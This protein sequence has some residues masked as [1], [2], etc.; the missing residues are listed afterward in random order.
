MSKFLSG[1]FAGVGDTFRL[2]YH[3]NPRAFLIGAVASLTEPLFY[4]AL[5]LLLQQLFERLT[6][7]VGTN[8]IFAPIGIGLVIL[9]LVQRL[10]II[11]RDQANTILRQEAWVV[12]SRQIMQKLPSVP[13]PMFE[14][15][16]FQARYGLVIREASYR[17]ITLVD[18]LLSTAPILLGLL[19]VVVTLAAKAPLMTAAILVIAIPAAMTERRFS[20]AMYALQEDSAPLHLRMDALTNMQVDATWQRDVRVYRSDLLGREHGSLARS[21]LAQLKHLT[22][23]FFRL[24]SA[25]ALVQVAGLGLALIAAFALLRRGQLSVA[26]LAVL[27]P[28]VSI[29]AGMTSSFVYQLRDLFESLA[30]ARALFEFLATPFSDEVHAESPDD[31]AN[32]LAAIGLEH[33]AFTYPENQKTAL[34]DVTY[35]FK[36]GLTAIVGTN[37]AGK[38]T[39]VKLIA[40]LIAPSSGELYVLDVRH[41]RNPISAYVKSVLFQDPGHFPFSIRHNVTMH[42]DRMDDEDLR[43][44]AV[45]RK[46]GLWEVVAA[47]PDGID[48]V[49]GAGFGGVTDLSGGQWQRLALAR[50]LYHDSPVI[51]LDEPSASLDPIGEREIFQFLSTLAHEKIILFTTHRYDTI[52]KADTIL[53]LVDGNIAEAGTHEE[54]ERK[55]GPFW[56]LYLGTPT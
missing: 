48:T 34:T 23:H 6:A 39:L 18:S 16:A 25:A 33:V 17:S 35:Q 15:N 26:G 36:P 52:R 50:L 10:G 45:L 30:Y 42:F 46:A 28:G 22:T 8:V 4:P 5:L 24:R 40:G 20:R 54:L 7:P 55:A 47:L 51:I 1:Q 56:S 49:V 32:N 19:G 21:Y 27:I 3:S 29:L 38:S 31:S 53:V 37:G 2:L 44:E 12:I 41:E 14:N 11:V 9:L 13:Y 43:I